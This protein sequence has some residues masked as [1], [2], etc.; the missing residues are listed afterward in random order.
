MPEILSFQNPSADRLPD[1]SD[2]STD[3]LADADIGSTN[4]I[5]DICM[6][7]KHLGRDIV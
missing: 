3:L 5:S 6:S 1:V 7:A 4:D 2:F